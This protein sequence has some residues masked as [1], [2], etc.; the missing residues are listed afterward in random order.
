MS[1]KITSPE[2]AAI[3][4]ALQTPTNFK[5]EGPLAYETKIR[6]DPAAPGVAEFIE[7]LEAAHAQGKQDINEQRARFNEKPLSAAQ[8]K[9]ESSRPWTDELDKDTGEPTGN[10]TVK[11]K[12]KAERKVRGEMI[13]QR[14][15]L[16]DGAGNAFPV[17]TPVWSGSTVRLSVE[18]RPYYVPA[19]GYGVSL[20]LKAVQILK[21]VNGDNEALDAS[22]FGFDSDGDAAPIQPKLEVV[23]EVVEEEDNAAAFGDF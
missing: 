15:A 22:G 9:K 3:W 6:L 5:G 21:V 17:D 16:F 10:L 1:K 14:P 4:P 2:G 7:A 8:L 18:P 11:A 23:P 12:L 13:S 20:Q 19:I